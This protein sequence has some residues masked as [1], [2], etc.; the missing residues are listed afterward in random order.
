M[1]C[2]LCLEWHLFQ[3]W[4]R[5]WRPTNTTYSH[6]Q[7]QWEETKRNPIPKQKS[8]ANDVL[9]IIASHCAP[10]HMYEKIVGAW[11]REIIAN[12][13]Y[14]HECEW[15][16]PN[17]LQ[18]YL[19]CLHQTIPMCVASQSESLFLVGFWSRC[20]SMRACFWVRQPVRQT[21]PGST[22]TH[23]HK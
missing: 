5:Q 14:F 12:Y 18:C 17:F 10:C 20:V 3:K 13:I 22:H 16:S 4:L 1:P 21:S 15:F 2:K 23:S 7:W 8:I 19:S 9:A 11:W 6:S